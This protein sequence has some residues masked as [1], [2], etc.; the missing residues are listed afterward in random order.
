MEKSP[1]FKCDKVGLIMAL[2]YQPIAPCPELFQVPSST[3]TSARPVGRRLAAI[4]KNS[5][6]TNLWYMAIPYKAIRYHML[7]PPRA[8]FQERPK[9]QE[10]VDAMGTFHRSKQCSWRVLQYW[11]TAVL[12]RHAGREATFGNYSHR[13]KSEPK[14]DGPV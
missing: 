9:R 10:E 4:C 14:F 8:E 12:R 13:S 5:F 3:R 11:L 2:N 6:N 1:F 7:G